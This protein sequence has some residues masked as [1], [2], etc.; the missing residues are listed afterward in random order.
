MLHMLKVDSNRLITHKTS[1]EKFKYQRKANQGVNTA[2]NAWD[3]QYGV[4]YNNGRNDI[5]FGAIQ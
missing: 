5:Q 3:K 4:S 1:N 2:Q